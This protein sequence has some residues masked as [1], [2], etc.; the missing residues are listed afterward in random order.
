M[1]NISLSHLVIV[2]RYLRYE[3]TEIGNFKIHFC[4]DKLERTC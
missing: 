1:L 3:N 2:L 4:Q